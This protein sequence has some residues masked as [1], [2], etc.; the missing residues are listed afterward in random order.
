[1][2]KKS[3]SDDELMASLDP[4]YFDERFDA[5]RELLSSLPHNEFPEMASTGGC[6]CRFLNSPLR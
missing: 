6:P 3:K 1:M 2:Q 4:R 5:V